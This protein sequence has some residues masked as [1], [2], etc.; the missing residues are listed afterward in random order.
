MAYPASEWNQAL[1]AG[2]H[3]ALLPSIIGENAERGAVS[4]ADQGP[5]SRHDEIRAGDFG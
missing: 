4:V 5:V 1:R 2:A 3:A